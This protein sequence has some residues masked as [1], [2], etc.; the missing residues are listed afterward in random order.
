MRKGNERGTRGRRGRCKDGCE[1]VSQAR[2]PKVS[3]VSNLFIKYL[4]SCFW[5]TKRKTGECRK[6][7]GDEEWYRGPR[8]AQLL[9]LGILFCAIY[10]PSACFLIPNVST[11]RD[12]TDNGSPFFK[13]RRIFGFREHFRILLET[14]WLRQWLARHEGLQLTSQNTGQGEEIWK[15]LP[16][17]C[18]Y[19]FAKVT[20]AFVR[21]KMFVSPSLKR[22]IFAGFQFYGKWR[23]GSVRR[24]GRA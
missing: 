5:S 17:Y 22:V 6:G 7:G 24:R 16:L 15:L 20:T 4:Q 3:Q 10:V 9:N 19:T 1:D 21:G 14:V 13:S 12:V 18:L 8:H 23:I 11:A 2:T